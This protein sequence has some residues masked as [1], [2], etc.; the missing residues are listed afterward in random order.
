MSGL[1]LAHQ[2]TPL[3]PVIETLILIWSDSEGEE[4]VNL[5][6]YLPF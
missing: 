4:W 6:A 5:I 3:P 1:L 2:L